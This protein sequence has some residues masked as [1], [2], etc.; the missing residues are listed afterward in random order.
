MSVA[1]YFDENTSNAVAVGVQRAGIDVLRVQDDD[2][3][4]ISDVLL[5]VRAIELDRLIFTHDDD[6]IQIA[7]QRE[8]SGQD[9]ASVVYVH[10]RRLTIGQQIAALILLAQS[11]KRHQLHNQVIFLPYQT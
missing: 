9:H 10:Q 4:G 8:S 6:L 11:L 2:R 7:R 3:R 5:F 1:F